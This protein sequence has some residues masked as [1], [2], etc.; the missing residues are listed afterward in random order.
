VE[1]RDAQIAGIATSRRAKLATRI[2]RHFE[3]TGVGLINPW[4]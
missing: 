1:I 3:G 2:T 4:D